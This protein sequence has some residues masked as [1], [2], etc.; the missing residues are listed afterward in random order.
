M[1]SYHNPQI[2]KIVGTI[3]ERIIINLETQELSFTPIRTR[4]DA[5]KSPSINLHDYLARLYKYTKCSDSCYIVAFIYIDRVLR[6]NPSILLTRKNIHRLVLISLLLAIKYSDDEYADNLHYSKIGGIS[7]SEINS[8]ES[9]MLVLVNYNL[10]IDP[11]LYFEYYNDLIIYSQKITQED[12]VTPMEDCSEGNIR[13]VGSTNSLGS[14]RTVS[15]SNEMSS[16]Q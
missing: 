11:C 13:T 14:I 15:S 9:E 6:N 16:M 2:W 7:L 4:F 3:L 1:L 10:Y 5:V 8:L 12:L